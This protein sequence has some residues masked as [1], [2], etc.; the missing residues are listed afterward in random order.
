MKKTI[1]TLSLAAAV[2]SIAV[3]SCSKHPVMPSHASLKLTFKYEIDGEALVFDEI[4]YKNAAD[5]E[6]SVSK[7]EYYISNITLRKADNSFYKSKIIQYVNA[8][9]P[10][11]NTIT[12][13]SIPPGNYVEISFLLGLSA[14]QNISN[15]LPNTNQ[16]NNMYW[17][18]QMGGGY[19][20]MKFEGS[21]IDTAD[22]QF[23]YAIHLGK[24]PYSVPAKLEKKMT[25]K[26]KNQELAVV[27]NLNEWFTNPNLFDLNAGSYT[28]NSDS[29]MNVVSKNGKSVFS[30]K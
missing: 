7:L 21:Y 11:T 29:L 19:H 27:M 16:H 6:Y 5:N 14:A 17:P 24:N 10:K 30:I 26:L 23:G 22:M 4:K 13:D 20:F 15:S 2:L 3:W 1:L 12:L 25:L 18:E 8:N 9:Q 28:M